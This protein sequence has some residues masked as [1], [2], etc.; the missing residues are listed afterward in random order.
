MS[1]TEN[2]VQKIL[3]PLKNSQTD[4][5]QVVYEFDVTG[6]NCT[7]CAGS[8]K[9][10]LQNMD[11]ISNVEIN[12]ASEIGEVVFDPSKMSKD[13][14]RK[15]VRNLGFEI[16]SEDEEYE[17]EQLKLLLL[18]K[19]RNNI[20]IAAILSLIIMAFSMKHHFHFLGLYK[21][22]DNISLIIITLLS[23]C[24]VFWCGSKFLK[25]ALKSL[26]SKTSDMNT[27][28]TLG[29][30]SSY[31]Y[32]L[33]ITVN[34]LFG[35]NILALSASKEVYFETSAMIITFILIGNYLEAVMKTKTQSSVKKLKELQT[36]VVNI[37]RDGHELFVPFKKVR[38][39]DTVIIKTGDKI[40][41][42]GI[43]TEGYC[44]TDESALTGESLPVEKKKGDSLI[45]G[46]LV[47]NGYVKMKA[48]KVGND[49]ML[50][51]IIALVKDAANT[52]PKIQKLADRISAVF[53]PVVIII[54]IVTFLVWYFLM[55][56]EFDK[57][58]LF[59]VSV[60]IIAC[61]C[62][63]GLASPIAIVIG[64]GRAAENGILFKNPDAIENLMKT[65][66]ICFDK[67]GTLTTGEM[68]VKNI[69]VLNGITEKELMKYVYTL[70]KLS[71]HPVA[72]SIVNYGIDNG[73]T[74]VKDV[75]DFSNDS[76]L[77][78]SGK[79]N[80]KEIMIGNE[81]FMNSKDVRIS[82]NLF[83]S[84]SSNL[85]VSID[86][87][88]SG[89]IEIEDKIKD[90]APDVIRKMLKNKFNLFMISGDNENAA[91]NT[92]SQLGI[93]NYSYK[94]LPDEKEKIVSKLQSEGKN[95]VM[96]GDG[97]NDAPSLA[98]SN[99]G[100]AIGTGQ[101]IAIDSADVILVKDDL[102]NIL[103]SIKISSKTVK[104]IKQ[105]FFWAFFYNAV[106]IPFAAGVFA[107]FGIIVSPVMAAMLMAFSDV[108]TVIGNSLRLKYT[109]LN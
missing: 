46:T 64:V 42:D 70:E 31:L 54:A 4:G 78:I 12:F 90:E 109:N 32:S 63:L 24:V 105:N 65:D 81:N 40:P 49:T 69:Y 96:I 22:P 73:L 60:L 74:A 104:I 108:V 95:V 51:K 11:G 48:E 36:K 52:K 68:R 8:I 59:A 7:G 1:N 17:F 35:L 97:I 94:T 9:T 5:N 30:M 102:N 89:A 10:Y 43:I 27:L 3:N 58:L 41:V 6:M 37:I 57:S 82:H 79:V 56:A 66:T 50:S 23:T 34:I 28:I 83:P 13:R 21:I 106:A 87:V 47:K 76:G 71:D 44:V 19:Q 100:M 67:T 101:E 103:K 29:S 98:K 85:F 53:V 92:A 86:S 55:G 80:R 39:N 72:R 26:K 75:T 15:E 77:G 91:R 93:E 45:S 61:P 20:F 38:V 88:I 25:G 18:K 107:P 62:A 14:I 33:L 99:V 16:S 2:I 84:Q